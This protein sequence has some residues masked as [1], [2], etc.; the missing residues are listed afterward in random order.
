[1][2]DEDEYRFHP[3]DFEGD[4]D[5][6]DETASIAPLVIVVC[7]GVGILLFLAGTVT[8]G[9]PVLGVE[10][11]LV[12]LSA[13]VFAVGLFAGSVMYLRQ[14]RRVVGAVHG[15]GA[16]GWTFLVFGTLLSETVLLAAG[17]AV[18]VVGSVALL[19]I[20]IRR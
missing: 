20:S 3:E 18:L 5:P 9:L 8:D 17:V 11:D 16:L 14:G 4:S 19:V 13:A 15:L 7:L 10:V 6:T 12:A 2:S 1:M